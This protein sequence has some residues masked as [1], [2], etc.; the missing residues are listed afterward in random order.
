MRTAVILGVLVY[1]QLLLAQVQ[2]APAPYAIKDAAVET[3]GAQSPSRPDPLQASP[4]HLAGVQAAAVPHNSWRG[5]SA[6][7]A[8]ATALTFADIELSQACLQQGTCTEANPLLPR[9]RRAAYGIEIPVTAAATLLSY[10]MKK[11]Q[12]KRWW[13]P[14]VRSGTRA[15]DWRRSASGVLKAQSPSGPSGRNNLH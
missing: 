10:R 4:E 8:A 13:L 5:F 2:P 3:T 14:P 15:R 11:H 7:T 6:L 1:C 12:Q 9:S